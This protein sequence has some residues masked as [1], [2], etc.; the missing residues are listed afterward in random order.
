[1]EG[2]SVSGQV[3]SGQTSVLCIILIICSSRSLVSHMLH[4][5][6]GP[7]ELV[8]GIGREGNCVITCSSVVVAMETSVG[9]YC[10]ALLPMS[11]PLSSCPPSLFCYL[12]HPWNFSFLHTDSAWMFLSACWHFCAP[13]PPPPRVTHTAVHTEPVV[14]QTPSP[15]R[16]GLF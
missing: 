9:G 4:S 3:S 2:Y 11:S 8:F 13:T 5:A 7:H 6:Y 14:E 15:T 10:A 1:M 16:F 12:Q